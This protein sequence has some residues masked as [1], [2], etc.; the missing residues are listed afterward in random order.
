MKLR[1]IRT[2]SF[3]IPGKPFAWRRTGGKGIIRFE[4]KDQVQSKKG[5]AE[6]FR[7][8]VGPE[9]IPH[10]GPVQLHMICF[11]MIA[12]KKPAWWQ[13]AAAALEIPCH[14][15]ADYDNLSKLLGDALNEIA[16]IDDRIIFD[17]RTQKFWAHRSR[18]EITMDFYPNIRTKADYQKAFMVGELI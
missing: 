9:F 7:A 14:Q 12:P 15:L 18:T 11:F 8:A 10:D 6:L 3:E 5:V 16:W 13:E 2:I 4:D 1:P 17:G